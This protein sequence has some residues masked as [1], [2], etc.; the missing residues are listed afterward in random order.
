[1]RSHALFSGRRAPIRILVFIS[2]LVCF[3]LRNATYIGPFLS[4]PGQSLVNG[5]K[6]KSCKLVFCNWLVV[7]VIFCLLVC[8]VTNRVVVVAV[9]RATKKSFVF[10]Q[11]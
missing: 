4:K 11:L 3:V 5:H 1:M 7:V 6:G 9:H 8:L 2:K 10:T